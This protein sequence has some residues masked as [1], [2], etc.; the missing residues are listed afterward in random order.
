MKKHFFLEGPIQEGKSTLL[1]LLIRPHLHEI[2]GFSSQRL[3]NSLGETVGFRIVS[4][5]ESMEL[6]KEYST[7][8]SDIFLNFGEKEKEFKPEVFADTAIRFLKESDGKKLIL[9]DEIGGVELMD[10]NFK[11]ELYRILSG[12]T[13]CVGVIKLEAS[14][15]NMCRGSNIGGDCTDSMLRLRKDLMDRFDA[16]I[17]SFSRDNSADAEN[18]AKAFFEVVFRGV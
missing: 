6:T 5:A 18:S 12:E 16:E 10:L 14:N 9:L 17:L 3:L 2:G 15:R 8:L 11:E 4:A 1:R 13:P 7:D